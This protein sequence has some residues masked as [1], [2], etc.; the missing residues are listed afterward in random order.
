MSS[1]DDD[2]QD[3]V[4]ALVR[5]KRKPTGLSSAGMGL[6]AGLKGRVLG[7]LRWQLRKTSGQRLVSAIAGAIFFRQSANDPPTKPCPCTRYS[8]GTSGNNAPLP[9][10]PQ[11]WGDGYVFDYGP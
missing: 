3:N 11:C 6:D 5:V 10:C 4:V 9:N 2:R 1:E 8:R 7:R